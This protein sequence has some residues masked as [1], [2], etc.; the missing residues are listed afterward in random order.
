VA[1]GAPMTA[2]A[3][4]LRKPPRPKKTVTIREAEEVP[5]PARKRKVVSSET[6]ALRAKVEA[7]QAQLVEMKAKTATTPDSD[8]SDGESIASNPVEV[9]TRDLKLRR[10]IYTKWKSWQRRSHMKPGSRSSRPRRAR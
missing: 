8:V 9:A 10:N 2:E 7:L 6:K 5:I 3:P 1:A 4:T